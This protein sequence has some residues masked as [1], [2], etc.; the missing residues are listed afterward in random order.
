MHTPVRKSWI[1]AIRGSPF[2]GVT[3]FAFVCT[4]QETQELHT[5][6]DCCCIFLQKET[7]H[8]RQLLLQKWQKVI[9]NQRRALFRETEKIQSMPIWEQLLESTHSVSTAQTATHLMCLVSY[10]WSRTQKRRQATSEN[11]WRDR[12]AYVHHRELLS[13]L[14]HTKASH[15]H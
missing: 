4:V 8:T 6:G 3:K 9:L 2:L 7:Y 15:F 5:W 1:A 10:C 14:I 12:R 13:L 11:L